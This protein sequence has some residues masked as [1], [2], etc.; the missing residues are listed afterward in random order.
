MNNIDWKTIGHIAGRVLGVFAVGC[1]VSNSHKFESTI[2][3]YGYSQAVKA[4]SESDMFS[5]DK[6][7]AITELKQDGNT[8]FYKAVIAIANDTSMFSSDKASMIKA[9]SN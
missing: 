8:E 3:S 2:T 5:G 4:I 7:E 1:L 6:R 9:L